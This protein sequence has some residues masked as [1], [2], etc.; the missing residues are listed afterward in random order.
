GSGLEGLGT[1]GGGDGT[2]VD[3]VDSGILG[4]TGQMTVRANGAPVNQGWTGIPAGF[5]QSGGFLEGEYRDDNSGHILLDS[6][7]TST[8]VDGAVTW[9][10]YVAGI[11]FPGGVTHHKPNLAIGQGELLDNRARDC[12]GQ[13]IGAGNRF[14]S[15]NNARAVYWIPDPAA[16]DHH[17]S[18]ASAGGFL[19]QQLI[20]AKIEW[21]DTGNDTVSVA[22]F[23]IAS[24]YTALTEADFDADTQSTISA[25]LDQSTFDTLSFHGTRANFDEFRIA[26][27]FEDVVTGTSA[28]VSDENPEDGDM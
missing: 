17:Y 1:P 11:A 27:T 15:Y 24:G 20:I 2:W 10:S 23:D 12:N 14:N 13:A 7:V 26:T 19:P 18:D 28:S 6:S 8:F 3:G 25:D 5:P 4:V 21:S 16:E 9:M 22:V